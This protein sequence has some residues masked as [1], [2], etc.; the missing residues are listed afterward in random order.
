MP[1]Q[2]TKWNQR[3]EQIETSCSEKYHCTPCTYPNC[4][5]QVR[6]SKSAKAFGKA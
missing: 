5:R 1:Q 6:L 4:Q 3:Y 2:V